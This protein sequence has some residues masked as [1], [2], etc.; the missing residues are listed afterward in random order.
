M[1]S[2]KPSGAQFR[3]RYKDKLE[4]KEKL[5]KNIPTLDSFFTTTPLSHHSS[6]PGTSSG[7]ASTST[8]VTENRP[9]RATAYDYL[10]DSSDKCENSKNAQ[11]E[12]QRHQLTEP[13]E[14]EIDPDAEQNV[15]E[16]EFHVSILF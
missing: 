3:Q 13:I 5:L 9:F 6:E 8:S 12:H 2:K 11:E 10:T 1:A 14:E 16:G 7:S 15:D 4:K